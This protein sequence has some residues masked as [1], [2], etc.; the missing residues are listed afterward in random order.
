MA[1]EDDETLGAGRAGGGAGGGAGGVVAAGG[2]V[3]LLVD[4]L[5]LLEVVGLPQT[6]RSG[7]AVAARRFRRRRVE[8]RTR[9]P[10]MGL[11][12]RRLFFCFPFSLFVF[13]PPSTI[14]GQARPL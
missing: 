2:V 7:R 12:V 5:V 11:R 8:T 10:V 14:S 3:L 4:V 13:N 1:V 6:G 9:V